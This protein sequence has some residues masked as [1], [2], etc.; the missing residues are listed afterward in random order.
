MV[1]VESEVKFEIYSITFESLIFLISN[2]QNFS[3]VL[4]ETHCMSITITPVNPV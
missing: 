4:Q 2:I 1:E 3:S